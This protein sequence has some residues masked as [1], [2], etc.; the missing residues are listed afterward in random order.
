[1]ALSL[2]NPS[3]M[4]LTESQGQCKLSPLRNNRPYF[5]GHLNI[6]KD[7]QTIFWR[8]FEHECQ[9]YFLVLRSIRPQRVS[10]DPGDGDIDLQSKS[11]VEVKCAKTDK[12]L[13]LSL[14]VF[15]P[16]TLYLVS[17]S[18]ISQHV[19]KHCSQFK[20]YPKRFEKLKK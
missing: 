12:Q 13:V 4:S 17:M 10:N 1:M 7:L 11:L 2:I 14:I 19:Q 20:T 8:L 5:G 16:Q 6:R 15:Y 18:Y 9:T 3:D